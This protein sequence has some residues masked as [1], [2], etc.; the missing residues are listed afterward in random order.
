MQNKWYRFAEDWKYSDFKLVGSN[1]R[2]I[3]VE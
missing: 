2:D 1:L 3:D